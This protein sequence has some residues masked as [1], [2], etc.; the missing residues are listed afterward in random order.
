M[1]GKMF[2]VWTL[3]FPVC[4]LRFFGDAVAIIAP[5]PFVDEILTI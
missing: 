3:M 2:S 5:M 1:I 4:I